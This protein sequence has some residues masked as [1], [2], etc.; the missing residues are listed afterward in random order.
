[1]SQDQD[2]RVGLE[3]ETGSL[4]DT[5][6]KADAAADAL[7]RM[8]QAQRSAEDAAQESWRSTRSAGND[9]ARSALEE[10]ERQHRAWERAVRS[11]PAERLLDEERARMAALNPL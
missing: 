8:A 9:P 1:M 10:A 11:N 3:I 7:A 4:D 2:V 5:A 6:R